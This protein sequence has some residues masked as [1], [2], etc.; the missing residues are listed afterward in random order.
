MPKKELIEFIEAVETLAT[1][2]VLTIGVQTAAEILTAC[3]KL[4]IALKDKK[5]ERNML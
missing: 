2:V 4:K 1:S 3:S 5:Q